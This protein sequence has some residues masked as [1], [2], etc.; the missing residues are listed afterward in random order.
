MVKIN[1]Q[2]FAQTSIVDWLKSQGRDSSFSARKKLA[3]SYGITNYTGT[4]EQNMLL[5]KYLTGNSSASSSTGS[6][7]NKTSGS[8][9]S[10]SG[11][12]SI[13]G[14]SQ[15]TIN[16]M[17]SSFS[18]SS[19][20]TQAK[21]EALDQLNKLKDISSVT[22]IV[23][24]STWDI[25]NTPFQASE[26]YQEAMK[27]TNQLLE[28]LS[29]GRTSYTD[30]IENL[31][32][33]I[34]NRDPF[35]YDV[36]SDVLFQQYLSSAMVSGK[37]A[38]Q[39]SIGM[40]SALTGGY[41]STYATTAGNQ[42]Y[43]AYIQDAYSNLPEYYQMALNAYQAEGEEMYNQL[44]ML[45]TADIN[46][47]QRTYDS[48]SANFANAQT[49]YENEYGAWQD[50]INNAYSS[51]NLQIQEHGQLYDQAYNTYS[52]L[53]GY[54]DSVYSQE[55]QRW[56]DEVTNAFNYA[57]LSNSDY[58]NTQNFN[59]SKRQFDANMALKQAAQAS[60]GSGSGSDSNKT[61]S[62]T[63]TDTEIN[64]IK[65]LFTTYNGGADGENAVL[66][67]LE[68]KGK[69][70]SSEEEMR[71]VESIFNSVDIA[72]AANAE[73][74]WYEQE[75]GIVDDTKNWNIFGLSPDDNNDTYSV[76]GSDQTYTY[77]EL[78]NKLD[79]EELTE[80]QKQE[81]LKKWSSQSIR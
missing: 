29:S 10:S 31:M 75:W 15:A 77:K 6:G 36:D 22:D 35:S 27:Y 20:V 53:Q 41:G 58:W 24:Q 14:V 4:A 73:T 43:N 39:D 3:E 1:L 62:Y 34:R 33:E 28:Q 64:N 61:K 47:Y 71:I 79:S 23:D 56:A 21:Q 44:E 46:E 40:A 26:A 45:N 51:A 7:S 12:G 74:K 50:S 9:S 80:A 70:P 30:D 55:Y 16:K 32:D 60:S 66:D 72:D 11:G 49:M 57:Q 42:M 13:N 17:N 52:A 68:Q 19:E 63:L 65:E 25:I 81:I 38:M 18:A 69:L 54:A 48:W 8:G 5:L 67:Y 59:E 37:T 2:L 76:E 78:K